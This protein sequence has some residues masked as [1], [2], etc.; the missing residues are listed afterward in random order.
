MLQRSQPRGFLQAT[1]VQRGAGAVLLGRARLDGVT[2][3]G[4]SND[5]TSAGRLIQGGEVGVVAGAPLGGVLAWSLTQDARS[6]CS[7]KMLQ[8]LRIHHK[9]KRFYHPDSPSSQHFVPH[10]TQRLSRDINVAVSHAILTRRTQSMSPAEVHGGQAV[11]P[12]RPTRFP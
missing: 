11:R 6:R 2:H 3:L 9:G 1:V 7:L 12:I 10:I 8:T 4:I 5:V